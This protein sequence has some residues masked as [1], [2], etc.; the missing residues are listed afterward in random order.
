MPFGAARHHGHRGDRRQQGADRLDLGGGGGDDDQAHGRGRRD[1]TDGVH[2]KGLAGEQAQGLGATRAQAE[3][4]ARGRNEDRD[5]TASIE[6]RGHV[7]VLFGRCHR[8]GWC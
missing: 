4:G 5:V 6:L 1:A 3:A 2:E 7:A 8:W